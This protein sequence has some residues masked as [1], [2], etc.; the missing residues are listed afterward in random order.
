MTRAT[1]PSQGFLF[2]FF[3]SLFCLLTPLF[4]RQAAQLK[5][6]PLVSE[7]RLIDL[8]GVS[9]CAFALRFSC[10]FFR[11]QIFTLRL[12]NVYRFRGRH[13]GT[14]S[15]P[16]Q[17]KS[18]LN[19]S[20]CHTVSVRGSLRTLKQKWPCLTTL[21]SA[22]HLINKEKGKKDS[23]NTPGRANTVQK[24]FWLWASQVHFFFL[25]DSSSIRSEA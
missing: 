18:S 1:R 15:D 12:G 14:S 10:A 7:V 11:M 13:S 9:C 19:R 22:H 23:T 3:L 6:I 8:N 2:F 25:F 21:Y 24:E 4:V 17:D 16:V 20:V 5:R